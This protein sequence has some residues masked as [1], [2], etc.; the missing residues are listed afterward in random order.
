MTH[1]FHV[2]RKILSTQRDVTVNVFPAV[3][4]CPRGKRICSFFKRLNL[5]QPLLYFP[6]VDQNIGPLW[7]MFG[8]CRHSRSNRP[9]SLCGIRA[10][11]MFMLCLREGMMRIPANTTNLGGTKFS[12]FLHM[13]F[14]VLSAIRLAENSLEL[15]EL[16]C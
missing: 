1:T 5:G 10:S 2:E 12:F 9:L 6:C 3:Q 13:F 16:D 8:K 4:L 11:F 15:F 7:Q 14:S